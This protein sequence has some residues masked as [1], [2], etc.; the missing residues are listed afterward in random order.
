MDENDEERFFLERARELLN[1]AAED[2]DS[3]IQERLEQIRLKA[4]TG[5]DDW[6]ERLFEDIHRRI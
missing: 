1:R 3:P 2:L 6:L 5:V 4:L